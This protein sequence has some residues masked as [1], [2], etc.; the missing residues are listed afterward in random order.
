VVSVERLELGAGAIVQSGCL[1]H[2]GGLDWSNGAGRIRLGDR[3]YVGH[4]CVLY[5]SGGL[6]VGRDV[7]IGP[8]AILTSQGHQFDDPQRLVREQPHLFAPVSIGDD[9]WIGAGALVLPGVTIGDG[10]IVA[11]GAV[12]T[13]DVGPYQVVAGTPAH[14]VR[15]RR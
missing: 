15:A 2:C 1:L 5:G 13:R 14:A 12:V 9:V 6:E 3:C 11:A 4:G 10:A 7:L 8:G